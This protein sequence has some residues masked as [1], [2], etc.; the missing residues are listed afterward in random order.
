MSNT[1]APYVD[2][3]GYGMASRYYITKLDELGVNVEAIPKGFWTGEFEMDKDVKEILKNLESQKLE[4][5]V[6]MICQQTP[7]HFNID[8]PGYKIGY[9]VHETSKVVNDWVE[10]MNEMDEIWTAS[11]FAKK[12]FKDS[13]VTVPIYIVP[14]G[15]DRSVFNENV[16]PLKTQIN[17]D[18]FKFLSIFQWIPRKGYDRLLKA[19]YQEFT[20][21]DD[22]ALIIKTFGLDES[23]TAAQHIYD[24]ILRIQAELAIEYVPPVYLSFDFLQYKEMAKLY[25][26]A[27]A[28]VLPSRGEAWGMPYLEAMSCGLPTIGTRWGGHLDFMNDE[29]SMLVDIEEL[30]VVKGMPTP[31]FTSDQRWADVCLLELRNAMRTLYED[32]EIC[33]KLSE[34][35]IETAKEWPWERG[36]KIMK[37]RLEEID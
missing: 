18:T 12:V 34:K 30:S 25:A 28:F 26:L 32:V 19:Y 22:V 31:W 3:S 11:T 14:H 15:V 16:E 24:S 21:D 29:N 13:G 4:N 35:G 10:Y 37:E 6:P 27:D 7:N 9:S 33:A 1:F 17:D 8:Y 5:D 23:V 20:K 36:A 2:P